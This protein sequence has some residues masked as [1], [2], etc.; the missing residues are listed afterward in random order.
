MQST[1]EKG[2]QFYSIECTRTAPG[3]LY[4]QFIWLVKGRSEHARVPNEERPPEKRQRIK[5]NFMTFE[6][7]EETFRVCEFYQFQ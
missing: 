5:T 3:T 1:R 4:K 2:P 6:M 7:V